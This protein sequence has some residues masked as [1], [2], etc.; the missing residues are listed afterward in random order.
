[1]VSWVYFHNQTGFLSFP[2]QKVKC[3]AR[4]GTRTIPSSLAC[5]VSLKGLLLQDRMPCSHVE[6]MEGVPTRQPNSKF[7]DCSQPTGRIYN[8]SS[9]GVAFRP[10]PSIVVKFAPLLQR[11][12]PAPGTRRLIM[13]APLAPLVGTIVRWFFV[14][15]MS[16]VA[17][18]L[19]SYT[20]EKMREPQWQ[21]LRRTW[22]GRA[23]EPGERDGSE[24]S[25]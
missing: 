24:A 20:V 5:T 13:P 1:V 2:P 6:S 21:D 16:S 23:E 10:R 11:R 8:V 9:H 7:C 17:W 19:G 3:D 18:K 15:V 22:T 14:G 4:C 12:T 25:R